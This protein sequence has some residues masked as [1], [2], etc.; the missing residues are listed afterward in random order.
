MDCRVAGTKVHVSE[1][2]WTASRTILW[3]LTDS[4]S[5]VFGWTRCV[6]EWTVQKTCELVLSVWRRKVVEC[7]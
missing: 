6:D 2:A 4:L 5:K 1:K 7:E 3:I